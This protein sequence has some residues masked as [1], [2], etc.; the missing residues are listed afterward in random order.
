MIFSFTQDEF[1]V[2]GGQKLK[3]SL[4]FG[5]AWIALQSGD[6]TLREASPLAQLALRKA[7]LTA[8]LL[9][10]MAQLIES[11]D[12]RLHIPPWVSEIPDTQVYHGCLFP[13]ETLFWSRPWQ[14][15]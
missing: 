4:E 10:E 11:D 1:Q 2:Q 14:K 8:D 6:S 13:C 3:N 7:P 12:W 15:E 9:K 5:R